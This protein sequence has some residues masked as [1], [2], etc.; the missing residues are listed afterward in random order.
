MASPPAVPPPPPLLHYHNI[1]CVY[2]S[3]PSHESRPHTKHIA[4]LVT[5]VY[6]GD[7]ASSATFATRFSTWSNVSIHALNSAFALFELLLTHAGPTPWTHAPLLVLLLAG[8][9]GVAY[10]THAT[11]GFYSARYLSLSEGAYP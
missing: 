6:W 4:F 3:S 5:I 11:Q 9:L 2:S 8:Y 10:I 7:L 1:P